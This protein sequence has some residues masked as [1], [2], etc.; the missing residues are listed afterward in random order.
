MIGRIYISG[1][2]YLYTQSNAFIYLAGPSDPEGDRPGP[3]RLHPHPFY[4]ST[5]FREV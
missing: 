2:A 5:P 1:L 4:P 3:P